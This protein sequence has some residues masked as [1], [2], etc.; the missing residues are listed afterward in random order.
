MPVSGVTRLIRLWTLLFCLGLGVAVTGNPTPAA[1]LTPEEM[2]A[3]PAL[4]QRARDLSQGL[5][6]LVCQNQSIDDS[7]AELARDLRTEVRR[8]L[9]AGESDA[10]ILDA[11]R[12]TYG[13]YVLLNPPISPSTWILWAAPVIILAGGALLVFAAR[14]R[15]ETPDEDSPSACPRNDNRITGAITGARPP[16]HGAVQPCRGVQPSDLSCVGACRFA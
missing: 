13:D 2:L 15:D 11:I 14:R 3:D 7:D 5:R 1:A 4:E 12:D 16:G 8:R 10:D 6:C 9:T